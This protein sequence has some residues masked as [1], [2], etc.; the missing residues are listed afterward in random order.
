MEEKR[1][2]HRRTC[3]CVLVTQYHPTLCDPWTVLARLLYSWDSPGKNTGVGCHFLLQGMSGFSALHAA[4]LPS[5]PP[6]KPTE[7]STG[8]YSFTNIPLVPTT[9]QM[10]HW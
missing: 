4:S 5:E 7:E 1:N 2:D 8:I 10:P 6:G 9:S 3:V